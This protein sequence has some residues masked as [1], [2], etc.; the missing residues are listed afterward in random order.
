MPTRVW[1]GTDGD[2]DTAGNWS[3][4]TIPL[5]NDTVILPAGNSYSLTTTLN[6]AAVDL[7][8]LEIDAGYT[9]QVGASGTPLKIDADL[10]KHYG[11]GTLYYESDGAVTDWF[12]VNSMSNALAAYLDGDQITKITVQSGFVELAATLG[13]GAITTTLEVGGSISGTDVIIHPKSASPSSAI[14]TT[15]HQTG[16]TVRSTGVITTANVSGGMLKQDTYGIATLN[17]FP[18]GRVVYNSSEDNGIL[19]AANV[20][21]GGI[22]DLSGTA[23]RKTITTLTL[24]HG[25]TLIRD[26]NLTTITTENDLGGRKLASHSPE[27]KALVRA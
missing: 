9:G 24:H 4:A 2:W 19:I 7:D 16:G 3:T 5:T 8:L 20:F 17:V 6:Q 25:S 12:I 22:L 11:R 26:P 1:Q 14:V 18:G 13:T 10:V 15:L 27:A 21:E 23:Y